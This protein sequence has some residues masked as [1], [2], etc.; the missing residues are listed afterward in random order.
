MAC[1]R[2][3]V[4][5]MEVTEIGETPA[6]CRIFLHQRHQPLTER[7]LRSAHCDADLREGNCS[8]VSG[9]RCTPRSF[10]P[11]YTREEKPLSVKE[12]PISASTLKALVKTHCSRRKGWAPY[13]GRGAG[14]HTEPTTIARVGAWPWDVDAGLSLTFNQNKRPHPT[15]TPHL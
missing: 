5:P 12:R 7:A 2:N 4:K 11:T 1:W 13:S 6:F 8:S 15:I 10:P 14:L 9:A 3:S